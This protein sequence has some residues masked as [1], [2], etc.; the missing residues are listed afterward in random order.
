MFTSD[1][2]GKVV[3]G[4][5]GFI[6]KIFSGVPFFH[7]ID[8]IKLIFYFGF[9]VTLLAIIFCLFKSFFDIMS[10]FADLNSY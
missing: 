3:T 4:F 10:F 8:S 1:K 7:K 5:S 2:I 9:F 6:D